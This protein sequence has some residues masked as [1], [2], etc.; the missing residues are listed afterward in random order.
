LLFIDLDNFKYINDALGHDKGDLLLQQVAQRLL[1]CVRESDTVARLG[2]DE[3]VVMLENLS[4]QYE[5][6]AS[7]AEL[8]AEKVLKHLS[9]V[10]DLAGKEHHGSTSIGIT[11]FSGQLDTMDDLLRR[12]DLAMYKAKESGRNTL[13]FFDPAM[14]AVV[15]A[16][17]ELEA[18]LRRALQQQEFVLHY[19]PQVDNDGRTTGAE[20]LVRWLHPKRGM[21]PPGDFIQLA[22]ESGLIL[23][24]GQWVMQTA[25]AQLVAW[26]QQP[27]LAHLTLAVNVSAHQ[28]RQEDFV[29]QVLSLVQATGADPHR[30]K[31]ELTETLLLDDVE[32][33]IAKMV[34]L[35]AHGIA[36][37]LDDFG[38]GYSSLAYLKRL[39]LYQLKIDRSFVRDVL[40]DPH[41]AAIASAIVA[42]AQNLGLSVI[43]EGVE[44]L[45]QRDFLAEHGCLAFQGYLFSKP[46]AVAQFEAWLGLQTLQTAPTSA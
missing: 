37:S 46:V 32:D 17:A 8:V 12:A 36:F 19:Q 33:I 31:L 4:E 13:R 2:G 42:M 34:A 40:S 7:L 24:L 16:R 15:M 14:Q 44:T 39:P 5:E 20:V 27:A 45:E 29:R 38:T 21:V 26:S 3:F 6:A 30:L 28:F 18:D 11:L 22:E 41:D 35:K 43:A 23:P 1:K 25:C 10:H 9:E